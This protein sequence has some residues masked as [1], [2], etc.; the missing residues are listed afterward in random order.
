MT[1]MLK[2][3][4][5][6]K[7]KVAQISTK[8]SITQLADKEEELL[9]KQEH[10]EKQIQ[11][12]ITI[13]K[14]NSTSNKRIALQALKRKKNLEKQQQHID[15]VLQTIVCQKDALD[16]ASINA[17]VLT[18]LATTSKAIKHAHN[19]MDIDKVQDIME[20]IE[21]Q[22]DIG[23]QIAEAITNSNNLNIDEN[24]LLAE[25]D[26]LKEESL[27]REAKKL[28]AS[29]VNNDNSFQSKDILFPAKSKQR[30]NELIPQMA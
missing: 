16:N 30:K 5:S 14:Q 24:E 1:S 17:D 19:G 15:G 28:P 23:K 13:A 11:E 10:L 25:L 21:E 20:E 22:Y 8:E 26:E 9:K 2:K 7:K 4:F 3:L 18:T 6:S 29:E 12:Q 27:S